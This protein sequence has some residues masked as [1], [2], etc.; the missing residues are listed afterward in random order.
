MFGMGDHPALLKQKAEDFDIM[1]SM[2][3]RKLIR[4]KK[5]LSQVAADS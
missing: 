1:D 5:T 4:T 2:V 3:S